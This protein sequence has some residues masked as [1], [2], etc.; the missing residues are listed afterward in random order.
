MMCL[1]RAYKNARHVRRIASHIISE[2][3]GRRIADIIP[4]ETLA[5]LQTITD[6][7]EIIEHKEVGSL[8]EKDRPETPSVKIS[9]P[10]FN[11]TLHFVQI[12]FNSPNGNFSVSE[13]DVQTAIDYAKHGVLDIS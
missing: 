13:P 7:K 12:T 5:R 9:G 10:L 6:P 2:E 8:L 1:T 11:G 3:N 4:P